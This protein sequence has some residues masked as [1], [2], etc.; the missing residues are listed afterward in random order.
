M[1]ERTE[2][3]AFLILAGIYVFLLMIVVVFG[4][5]DHWRYR[6]IESIHWP[7]GAG[8]MGEGIL[9]TLPEEFDFSTELATWGA[10]PVYAG[11]FST[12]KMTGDD[13]I[14]LPPPREGEP[15]IF[16]LPGADGA[17]YSAPDPDRHF[18]KVGRQEY[19][20][21][22]QGMDHIPPFAVAERSK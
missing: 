6:E 20:R 7:T 1:R 12:K 14:P 8:A 22:H 2:R 5:R 9:H 18:L 16:L 11:S 4:A 19:L 15:M 10:V 13:L 17:N 21:V 3:N